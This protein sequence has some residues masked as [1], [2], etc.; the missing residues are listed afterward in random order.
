[1]L[2]AGVVAAAGPDP[3]TYV[4]EWTGG[5]LTVGE[6]I[7]WWKYGSEGERPTLATPEERLKFLDPL[8]NADLMIEEAES[9]GL[10]ELPTVADFYKGRRVSI[11]TEQLQVRATE[12]RITIDRKEVDDILGKRM[13]EMDMKQIVVPTQVEA[14][15]LVDSLKAGVA[16]EELAQ[17][18]S[19]SPTGEAGGTVG[20]VR[21]GD[22]SERWSAQ[23]YR[24][25]PGQFSE[26]FQ[27]EGGYCI[28]KSYGKRVAAMQDSLA[29]RK[30]VV[31]SLV[32]EA[33]LRERQ[34]YLDSLKLAYDYD[35]DV[36]AVV[37]LSTKYAVGFARL[38]EPTAVVDADVDPGLTE[39]EAAV[40]L[41]TMKG[42]TLTAGAMAKIVARTPFQ[43]RPRVD[44]PDD[45]IPFITRQ[46]TDSL[47][48]AEA[49]KL[50]M[51]REEDVINMVMK[52]KRRKTLFAFYEFITRD[53]A[54]SDEEARAFYE[55]NKQYFGL[56][57]GYNVSKIIV[58]TRE[59]ADS[60]M[61]RLGAGEAFE[62]IA[63]VRSR[64][65]FTAPQGG[66]VGFLKKGSDEEF[67]GFL[68]TMQPGET[69]VF[70]SLEGFAVLWLRDRV[71]ARSASFE[72]A[73]ST[74]DQ[75]L[76]QGK[77]DQ[78]LEQWIMA[79]RAERGVRVNN[80]VLQE[81]ELPTS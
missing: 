20:T 76:T 6:F 54:I 31:N 43:V 52:A 32:R 78:A 24:L 64:D 8:I 47:L 79:R 48:V 4:A 74:I 55:A 63:R 9:L 13:T 33:T 46:S 17:R 5:G 51:D 72:E 11:L 35:I 71:A 38:G 7:T 40:P 15:A 62:D 80:E 1:V 41:V 77:K 58:G 23:A 27:V 18:Y 39:A 69:K 3:S 45:F 12:G 14:V 29:E 25:E 75:R 42:K 67:D 59:A 57:E 10:T 61:A 70:R 56:S 68:A 28:L 37:D 30:K 53:V 22:F 66:D 2:G 49:E 50:G 21:W 19:A 26:P 16:F 34:S 73:R 44:E 60:V 65:P 36:N 81:I